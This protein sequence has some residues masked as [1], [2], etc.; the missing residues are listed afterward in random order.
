ML[1]KRHIPVLAAEAIESLNIKEKDVVVDATLGSG[2]HS[3][4]ILKKLNKGKLI[5]IDYSRQAIK[6][7][8]KRLAPLAKENN[9]QIIFVHNNFVHLKNI[10]KN[11]KI[12]K[13]D[14]IIADLG[15]RIEQLDA[16]SFKSSRKLKMKIDDTGYNLQPDAYEIINYAEEE[17]LVGIFKQFGQ[18]PY[19]RFIAK[20]ICKSRKNQP[21]KTNLELAETIAVFKKT[22]RKSKIHPATKIFQALRIFI[23]KEIENLENFLDEAVELLKPTGRLAVISYHSLEDK[24][25]KNIFQANARGCVCPKEFPICICG[26]KERIKLVNRKV[27]K[28]SKKEILENPK[29]RSARLRVA[30]KM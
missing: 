20:A 2:G 1:I 25:V 15:W 3:E 30:E 8:K 22:N 12:E 18:E 6:E 28:P 4:R 21:I 29:S 27:I 5:A 26:R 23:N 13:A 10:L 19:A 14:S 7:S 16:T 9:N 11:L 24:K 17:K